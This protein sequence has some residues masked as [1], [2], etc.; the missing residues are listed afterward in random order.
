MGEGVK[1]ISIRL[2]IRRA[3]KWQSYQVEARPDGYML[4]ALEA[5]GLQDPSLLFRHACHHASCG[6]CGLRL[7]GRECLPCITPLT[8]F[9]KPNRALRLEPLRNFPIIGDLLVDFEPFMKQLDSINMPSLRA[10]EESTENQAH[11]H[12]IEA[13]EA[14]SKSTKGLPSGFSRMEN[15]I[16]CGLCI[17]ACPVVGS[18]LKYLGPAGLAAAGRILSEPRGRS[19]A[20]VLSLVDHEHGLWRCHGAFECSEVCPAGVEP[21]T[22]IMSL[23]ARILRSSVGKPLHKGILY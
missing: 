9:T 3:T 17:S 21:A 8:K 12:G 18:D 13:I 19:L 14:S 22:E 5:A 15:C 23:R 6:S 7:N 10:S 11:G 2:H 20:K 1:T 4:D 16:E